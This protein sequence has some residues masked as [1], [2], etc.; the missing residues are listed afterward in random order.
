MGLGDGNPVWLRYLANESAFINEKPTSS[1]AIPAQVASLMEPRLEKVVTLTADPRLS[2]G[3]VVADI[4]DLAQRTPG[5]VILL[6]TNSETGPIDPIERSRSNKLHNLF[7]D[8]LP[9]NI[10]SHSAALEPN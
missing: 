7:F 10:S 5:L 3:E 6:A 1:I 2:Y 4:S 8:C 9:H